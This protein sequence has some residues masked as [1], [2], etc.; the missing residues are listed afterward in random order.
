M[1]YDKGELLNSQESKIMAKFKTR[2]KE[3]MKARGLDRMDI[4]RDAHMSYPTVMAWE[5]GDLSSINADTV[6]ALL[7]T[8]GCTMDEL[9]Y[10]IEDESKRK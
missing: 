3:L 1:G 7:A 8:L 4:V 5:K 2:L 10:T 9:L 6:H